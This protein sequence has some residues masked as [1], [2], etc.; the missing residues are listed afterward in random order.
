[1]LAFWNEFTVLLDGHELVLQA[2]LDQ[3]VAD[4]AGLD[5]FG[6]AVECDLHDMR[7]V[8]VIYHPDPESRR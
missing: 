4:G 3:Q 8:E 2:E 1:M 6:V 7:I 5:S